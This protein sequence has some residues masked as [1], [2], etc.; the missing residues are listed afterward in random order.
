MR[1]NGPIELVFHTLFILFILAPLVAVVL[2]SFTSKGYLSMPTD[3]LSL[4]W[5]KAIFN[6]PGFIDAFW[7][8]LYLGIG[9]STIAVAR[10]SACSRRLWPRSKESGHFGG[11]ARTEGNCSN[12][13]PLSPFPSAPFSSASSFATG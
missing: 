8:S 1:R 2:V 10:L 6:Y 7:M 3:G 13:L 9:A 4:R 11:L 12:L 5:F